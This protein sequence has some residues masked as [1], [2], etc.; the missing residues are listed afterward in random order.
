MNF[1]IASMLLLV[2]RHAYNQHTT[3]NNQQASKQPAK[4]T[5]TVRSLNFKWIPC[6]TRR[7][8]GKNRRKRPSYIAI[9]TYIYIYIAYMYCYKSGI[10]WAINAVSA[11]IQESPA[12]PEQEARPRRKG[13]TLIFLSL[14]YVHIPCSPVYY[15]ISFRRIHFS[16]SSQCCSPKYEFKN[17]FKII[18][19]LCIVLYIHS[20]AIILKQKNKDISSSNPWAKFTGSRATLFPVLFLFSC[21]LAAVKQIAYFCPLLLLLLLWLLV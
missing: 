20:T 3:S 15:N 6:P 21:W 8:I 14:P 2:A 18:D 17:V 19:L 11:S 10:R 13:A 12:E 4:A 7:H 9:Y 5:I 1:N 16:F